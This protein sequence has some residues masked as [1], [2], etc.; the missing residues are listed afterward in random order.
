MPNARRAIR[1]VEA[2]ALAGLAHGALSLTAT[3]LLV[4]APQPSDG[5]VAIADWYLSEANQRTTILALN[6]LTMGTIAFLWFV[7]VVRRRVGQRENRFFGT[8][9]LGS[10]LLLGG[11]WFSAGVLAATPALAANQ[12][13]ATPTAAAVA[14]TQAA[15]IGLAS[16]VATR[17]EA[18]F[19]VSMT[20]VG[21]MSHAFPRWWIV[22]GYSLGL[23]LLLVPV[24][25]RLLP[26]LFPA[27]V[28]VTS[29]VLLVRRDELRH[30]EVIAENG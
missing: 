2:A 18:V 6:L 17:F 1:S 12:L 14:T 7:A 22:G 28:A 16:V 27:W 21:R 23:V 10:A 11:A 15:A 3:A 4:R 8:V 9:F 19:I 13:A 20:T 25:S 29:I 5:D 24:P 26:L 30:D